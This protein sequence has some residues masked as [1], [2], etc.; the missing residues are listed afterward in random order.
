[1][2]FTHFHNATWGALTACIRTASGMSSAL[3]AIRLLGPD[4]Y[5]HVV[6]WLSLYAIYLSLNSSAFTILMID[7]YANS[8]EDRLILRKNMTASALRLCMWSIA[9][10][11][12]ITLTLSLFVFNDAIYTTL[13]IH[14]VNIVI[15]LMGILTAVQIFVAL[16]VAI[17]EGSGRIDLAAKWQLTGPLI[18]STILIL[19]YFFYGPNFLKADTYIFILCCASLIDMILV[20]KIRFNLN[21]SLP[22]L[23]QIDGV[24]VSIFKLLRSGGLLQAT[25]IMN[26]FLEPMNKFL[27]NHYADAAA[28]TYYDLVMKVIWGI[29]HFVGSAMRVFLHIGSQ[30]LTNVSVSF[31]KAINLIA[32]P[33]IFLHA[34]GAVFLFWAA[35]YWLNVEV[36]GLLIFFSIATISNLGMLFVMPLYL[37]LI[38]SNQLSFIFQTQVILAITNLAISTIFIPLVGLIGASFGL[39]VA[40]ILNAVLIYKKC[41]IDPSI[42]TRLE[43]LKPNKNFRFST[44]LVFL[45]MTILWTTHGENQ[46]IL[47]LS[48]FFGFIGVLFCEPLVKKIINYIFK[49]K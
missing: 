43:N 13:N 41:D 48:I 45:G 16:Q 2:V 20:W 39:L 10:L 36:V 34:L 42:Y 14:N 1:M 46:Y 12:I 23:N 47:L 30:D 44:A 4:Q 18:I 28:V 37:S 38:G 7:L 9:L 15:F 25:T 29:Q 5:G 8:G 24:G 19:I 32:I 31:G 35:S 27:L 21:L 22:V 49:L 40:T 17:I 26:L 3:L 33:V 6:T 11:L